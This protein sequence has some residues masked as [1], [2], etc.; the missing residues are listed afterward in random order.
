MSIGPALASIATGVLSAGGGLVQNS[1]A[2]REAEKNRAF[3]ERMSST[4]AQRAVK[5]YALAGLNPAL[6]YDRPASSAGGAQAQVGDPIEKGVNSA[7]AAKQMMAQLELT[8]ASTAKMKAEAASA[9]ADAFIKQATVQDQDGV[10]V[11]TWYQEQQALRMARMRDANFSGAMQPLD[12]QLRQLEIMLRKAQ[13]PGAQ[14]E[15]KMW[16]SLGAGGKGVMSY[17][18]LVLSILK[19]LRSGR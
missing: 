13:V 9:E 18:P 16:E 6:A 11:P 4:A 10:R 12:Q 1:S 5:D 15:A 2:R 3:Q 19:A 14:A 17:G 8:K 7:M